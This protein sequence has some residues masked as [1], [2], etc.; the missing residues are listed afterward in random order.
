MTANLD[1]ASYQWI[2]SLEMTPLLDDTSQTTATT[3]GDYAVI[4]SY[5]GCSDTSVCY[6]IDDI[7]DVG[8]IENGFGNNLLFYPNPKDG[9][10]SIDLGENYGEVTVSMSDLSGRK[11]FTNSYVNNQILKMNIEEE[12]GMYFLMIEAE[13][14]K[15]I[16]KLMKE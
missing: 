3:N 14:R 2:N 1:S 11:T 12:T 9:N 5:N 8:I 16:I 15:A 4:I 7:E 10:L 6:T 13:D